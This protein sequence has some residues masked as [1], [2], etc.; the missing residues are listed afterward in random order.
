LR[1]VNWLVNKSALGDS[2]F[3]DEAQAVIVEA[4]IS[5]VTE[6]ILQNIDSKHASRI[7]PYIIDDRII[8]RRIQ[9]Q[10]SRSVKDVKL[11]LFNPGDQ[12]WSLPTGIE[13]S[14]KKLLPDVIFIGAMEDATN[15]VTKIAGTTAIGQI[16]S[17][18]TEDISEKY[19][20]DLND[21]FSIIGEK[22]AA[23]ANEKDPDLLKLDTVISETL[24]KFLPGLSVKTHMNTPTFGDL[25]KGMTLKFYEPKYGAREGI[26]A[27]YMG[28]GTQRTVQI[29]LL[30]CLADIKRGTEIHSGRSTILLIDEPELY[31]HPQAVEMT[32][33]TLRELSNNGFQV[34]FST[35]SAGMIRHDDILDAL[36]VR[37]NEESGTYNYYTVRSSVQK[38]IDDIA[39]QK[40]TIFS[41]GNASKFLFSERVIV[42][43][44][45]TEETILPHLFS[46]LEGTSLEEVG[47][48][49]IN[50][51]K[52]ENTIK[53]ADVLR[54]LG[55]TVKV[56]VDLDFAFQVAPEQQLL[57][58]REQSIEPCKARFQEMAND[59]TIEL[60]AKG[61]PKNCQKISAEKSYE[62]LA[63]YEDMESHIQL[64]HE[65]LLEDSYWL[66]RKGAFETH[67]G[68]SGKRPVHRVE[69]IEKLKKQGQKIELPDREGV[70]ELC[71]WL[72][73]P[74]Q[75]IAAQ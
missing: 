75:A 6:N 34:I 38:A 1:A 39:H 66:W 71:R 49:V 68:L 26:D 25:M 48:T 61:L 11:E 24:S 27:E 73:D 65:A 12:T 16:L 70:F 2:E 67:L 14:I 54:A 44:G 42:V 58:G 40:E 3:Y 62:E 8:L 18:I 53:V 22:M 33:N 30:R 41:L 7:I 52:S 72:K 37:R 36:M 64:L 4:E 51:E 59:G 28:H 60:D 32:R 35:H 43:E 57:N 56:I 55:L 17:S 10:P 20:A 13:A 5:G 47:A 63:K 50:A 69:F 19:A 29:S 9:S 74:Q 15:D 46:T 23:D 31:L 45:K 21:A